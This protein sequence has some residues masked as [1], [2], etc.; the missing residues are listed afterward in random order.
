MPAGR[1]MGSFG[2]MRMGGLGGIGR[3]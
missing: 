2:G 1:L 3:R